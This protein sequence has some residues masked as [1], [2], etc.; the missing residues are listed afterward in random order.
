[1]KICSALRSTSPFTRTVVGDSKRAWPS[2]TV[3]LGVP[4]SHVRD[5]ALA[6]SA[7]A[8][9]RALTRFMST[10]TGPSMITP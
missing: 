1:M 6:V 5:V 4:F 3:T 10:P 9:L 8:S 7:T 2:I